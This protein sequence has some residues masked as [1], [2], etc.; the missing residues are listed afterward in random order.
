M[1]RLLLVFIALS[2]A[3]AAL[4]ESAN[5]LIRKGNRAYRR[6]NYDK[7]FEAYA[8]AAGRDGK[9]GKASL[10][11][12]DALYRMGS[13]EKS[14]RFYEEAAQDKSTR[15]SALYNAGNAF[16]RENDYDGAVKSYSA[17]LL[18]GP[19]DEDI[20]HNLEL[21][22]NSKKKQQDKQQNKQQQQNQQ[23]QNKDNSN[24]GGGGGSDGKN[25]PQ[26][27][28]PKPQM[29]KEDA[30]RIMQMAKDKED[31]AM[32]NQRMAPV[33]KNGRSYGS[34]EDW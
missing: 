5:S 11:A 18:A 19:P 33:Q 1:K 24:G 16:Y 30:S 3:Q 14:R 4:A 20:R 27:Q 34:N 31:A 13:F 12:G 28:Q 9:N 2:C 21:A 25:G 22:L 29:A 32:Q 6:E 15:Q 26:N 17:A 8:Q 7:A 10:N 23:Q